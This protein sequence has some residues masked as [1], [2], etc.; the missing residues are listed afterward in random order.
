MKTIG[1]LGGMSWESSALYYRKINELVRQKLGGFH[2]AKIVMVSLD[3]HEVESYQMKYQWEQAGELLAN[4]ARKLEGAGADFLVL[5]TNTMHKVTSQIE[6]EI[7]IPLL[8]IADATAEAIK[9]RG[10][11][12][13]GLLG[14][15]FTMEEN[16]YVDRLREHHGLQVFIPNQED[17]LLVNRVIFEELVLGKI[18]PV[19]R[20]E[21]LRIMRGLV[22]QGAEGVIEGCTEIAML[23]GREDTDIPLFDSTSIHAKKAVEFALEVSEWNE[24]VNHLFSENQMKIEIDSNLPSTEEYNSLRQ[25]AGWHPY[26]T[27]EAQ[28][29]LN[30][31]L[32][33]VSI[34][35]D[36]EIIAFGRVI[37]DGAITF[38]VQ[39]VIVM[40]AHRGQG[41]AR[42]IVENLMRYIRQ[43][44]APGAVV[45]LM[46]AK[47][48]EG[49][50][51]K[52]GFISR[53]NEE[54]MGAGM[55]LRNI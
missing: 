9:E 10:I 23:V 53:P 30:N 34:R 55:V 19:S 33:T 39:D 41:H 37:G 51:E 46:S 15:K 4:S 42:I 7:N 38:Y 2:S 14:T 45:G 43:T 24:G 12:R 6:K 22:D 31:S 52:F 25:A 20:I 21:Y 50:Y 40:P 28:E 18:N 35:E 36:G 5:C 49:L 26:N 17:R 1:L 48:V 13:I 8:H 27:D 32:Y 11:E 54:N 44:A 47:G 16:F 3:F 29:G